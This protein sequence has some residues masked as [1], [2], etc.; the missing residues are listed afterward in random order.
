MNQSVKSS[1]LLQDSS[2]SPAGAAPYSHGVR[3]YPA[4]AV[5]FLLNQ[6]ALRGVPSQQALAGSGISAEEI[7]VAST[8]FSVL[9]ILAVIRNAILH[10]PAISLQVGTCFNA[11]ACGILGFAILSSPNRTALLHTILKY[12][13]LIDPLTKL[14]YAGREG[15]AI[16]E[17]EPNLACAP[18]D[19]LYRFVVELKMSCFRAMTRDLY[20]DDFQ[21]KR[22][23]LRF[24]APPHAGDYM[25]IFNCD[26]LFNQP[27]NEIVF[28][29][30][31]AGKDRPE[32]DAITHAMMLEL[33]E[34]SLQKMT[35]NATAAGAV[36]MI[37]L[38]CSGVYP[39]IEEIARE[40]AVNARTLRRR[41][42]AEGTSYSEILSRHRMQL[43][44]SYL[45]TS[46]L[47]NNEIAARLGYSDATNFR[48]AFVS[49]AGA[50]PSH[51]RPA[52]PPP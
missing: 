44:L 50:P 19:P 1:Q 37:L 51:F 23:S 11:S 10:A 3:F 17:V 39:N 40:L 21:F 43:A 48:R 34:Q 25:A 16:W 12:N 45:K 33:C 18:T 35:R 13:C 27:K 22:I 2:P 5:V 52:V 28:K 15:W 6:L 20:G 38:G 32:A 26:I 42:E 4:H 29:E 49:W 41:L 14:R 9:Q 8:R 24:P 46:D 30:I 36:L 7:G 47:N 31:L